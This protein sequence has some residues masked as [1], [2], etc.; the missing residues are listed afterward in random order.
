MPQNEYGK[1]TEDEIDRKN[2][3]PDRRCGAE[4][5]KCYYEAQKRIG[6]VYYYAVIG[7]NEKPF[8]IFTVTDAFKGVLVEACK[9]AKLGDVVLP[10]LYFQLVV[11]IALGL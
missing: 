8:Q 4:G 10:D 7:L 9:A 3:N 11:K 5:N 1:H 2:G 6:K